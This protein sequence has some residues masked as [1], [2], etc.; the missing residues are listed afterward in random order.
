MLIT[1]FTS[2]IQGYALIEYSTL[3]EAREAIA[4]TNNTK[5]IDQTIYV[6]FAFVRPP[7]GH[8]NAN[9][10]GGGAGGGFSRRGGGSGGGDRG[11]RGG[12]QRS[13]SPAAAKEGDAEESATVPRNLED[14]IG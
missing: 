9:R 1:L 10:G 13:R 11:G 14:R 7:P 4:Q 2:T 8:N 6:D 3:D 5:L 12:R